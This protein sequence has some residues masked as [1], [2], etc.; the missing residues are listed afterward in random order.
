MKDIISEESAQVSVKI[1][2]SRIVPVIM[3]GGRSSRMGFDKSFLPW[4]AMN[5]LERLMREFS[6]YGRIFVTSAKDGRMSDFLQSIGYGSR[7]QCR[8]KEEFFLQNDLPFRQTGGFGAWRG[9]LGIKNLPS[10]VTVLYDETSDRGPIE[11][12]RRAAENV[13]GWFMAIAVDM[14]F[15]DCEFAE[16]L[17]QFACGSFDAVVP[18]ENGR[19]NPLCALDRAAGIRELAQKNAAEGIAKIRLL[20]ESV[21]TKYADLKLSKF[22]GRVLLNANTPEDFENIKGPAPAC[23]AVSGYKNSGKTNLAAELIKKFSALGFAV[24]AVK[25]DGHDYEMDRKGTDTQKF[26]DAGALASS[27][28][29]SNKWSINSSFGEKS[30][31]AMLR[32]AAA[33]CEAASENTGSSLDIILAEGDKKGSLPKIVLASEDFSAAAIHEAFG[34]N[35]V[36]IAVPEHID[37]LQV[38][39]HLTEKNEFEIFSRDDVDGI[40]AAAMRALVIIYPWLAAK[41]VCR[42]YLP[43]QAGLQAHETD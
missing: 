37:K 32:S 41:K 23:I 35:V 26:T 11:G 7:S 43:K 24:G 9:L 18:S 42:P 1:S 17:W 30:M 31:E 39:K 19:S 16:Y 40:F 21:R 22:S 5:L 2:R 25:H 33:A 14:P 6:S 28:Y 15:V 13:E 34:P 8:D 3:A 4:G 29:S 10:E 12:L 27:I 38:D 36:G 20:L